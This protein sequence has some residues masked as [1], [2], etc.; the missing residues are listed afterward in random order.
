[1]GKG[2]KSFV[3]IR[4]RTRSL[5]RAF[6]SIANEISPLIITS[7]DGACRWA[8]CTR[9]RVVA[10]RSLFS[11]SLSIKTKRRPRVVP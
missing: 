2:L 3:I 7:P 4:H 5:Y 11:H 8:Q 6:I 10:R 9:A 1:M